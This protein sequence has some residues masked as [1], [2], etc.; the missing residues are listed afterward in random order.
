[1]RSNTKKDAALFRGLLSSAALVITAL[2][3]TAGPVVRSGSGAAPADIQALVTAFRGD[4]GDPNNGG[5]GGPQPA[6]RREINWDGV[7]TALAA[8]NNLPFDQFRARGS[9]FFTPGSG[10][11]VSANAADGIGFEFGNL[12]AQYPTIFQPFS[13]QKLFTSIGSNITDVRFVLAG[14]NTPATVSGFGSVFADVD[15]ADTTSIQFFDAGDTSLGTFFAPTADNGLSFLGVSFDAGERIGRVRITSGNVVPGTA[16]GLIGPGEFQDAVVM[17][18][19]LFSEPSVSAAAPE[20]G[21]LAL[22]GMG[23]LGLITV[24]RKGRRKG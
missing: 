11:Q 13:G 14:T 22:V 24:V 3:A 12:N 10:F 9:L 21:T 7:G 15:L 6:G 5:G 20:P 1:M 23:S 2:P 18:D 19:F 17:D 4:L 8:P 16:D